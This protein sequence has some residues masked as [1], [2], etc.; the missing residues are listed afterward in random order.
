ML[1]YAV[2]GLYVCWF[3][4]R[5]RVNEGVTCHVSTSNLFQIIYCIN[6]PF[7]DNLSSRIVNCSV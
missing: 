3:R 2:S 4:H 6:K 1:N 7:N 5:L